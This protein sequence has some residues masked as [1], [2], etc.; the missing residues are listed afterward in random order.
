MIALVQR[1]TQASVRIN[2]QVNGE[3]EHGIM[4]LLGVQKDD[5]EAKAKRMAE[6][7]ASYR[8]FEDK[9][10]KINLDVGQVG[11]DILVVSQFTLAADTKSGKRPSFS[12]CADPKT[13]EHLYHFFCQQLKEKGFRVPTGQFGADMQVSLVNDGPV[14]FSLTV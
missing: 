4:L 10:G 2:G 8:M 9:N 7:V 14:T 1:V 13:G 11:G 5:D 3:I 12:T 6:R